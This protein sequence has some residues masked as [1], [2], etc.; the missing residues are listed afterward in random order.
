MTRKERNLAVALQLLHE[1]CEQHG[2]LAARDAHR[3]AVALLNQLVPLDC[4][5]KRIPD[6]FSEFFDDAPLYHLAG[7]QL[8]GHAG[9]LLVVVIALL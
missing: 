2:V 9:K 1:L 7:R 4:E 3:D 5:D 8:F 6:G